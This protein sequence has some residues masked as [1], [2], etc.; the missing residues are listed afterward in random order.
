M[1]TNSTECDNRGNRHAPA[2]SASC[3]FEEDSRQ[4]CAIV[5]QLRERCLRIG[6]AQ[7]TITAF[8]RHG[9]DAA[10][11]RIVAA[12]NSASTDGVL[13]FLSVEQRS[14]ALRCAQMRFSEV[15]DAV[16]QQI[17]HLWQS[18]EAEEQSR[19]PREK[20]DGRRAD[21]IIASSGE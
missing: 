1:T 3:P 6:I 5:R 8:V 21:G 20:V 12:L 10:S 14:S 2:I 13:A 11:G 7:A 16:D 19:S 18:M 9:N 15:I 4:L 17:D